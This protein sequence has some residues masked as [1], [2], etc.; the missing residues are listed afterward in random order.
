MILMSLNGIKLVVTRL[1]SP[2]RIGLLRLILAGIC[3]ELE[4]RSPVILSRGFCTS[5]ARF[6]NKIP[7][8]P[9]FMYV[10][11]VVVPAAVSR[12]ERSDRVS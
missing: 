8:T 12:P 7:V 10:K 2:A 6:F 1:A 3:E 11:K 9:H 4:Y 5:V